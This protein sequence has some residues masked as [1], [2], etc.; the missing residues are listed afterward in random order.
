MNNKPLLITIG[1]VFILI[2]AAIWVYLFLYGAPDEPGEVYAN[3]GFELNSQPITVTTPPNQNLDTEEQS[4]INTNTADNPLRQITTR[5]V[6]GFTHV[7]T[8]SSSHVRY[9]ERGTGYVYDINLTTGAETAVSQITIPRVAEAVFSDNGDQVAMTSYTGYSPTSFAGN[10]TDSGFTYSTLEPDAH[11][12]KFLA[13]GE[14]LYAVSN[15]GT[16]RGYMHDLET[17]SRRELFSFDF[18]NTDVTW[19]SDYDA[20]YLTTRPAH[21]LPGYV[22]TIRNNTVSPVLPPRVNMHALITPN[23]TITTFN[24]DEDIRTTAST[25][26]GSQYTLPIT[27]IPQKCAADPNNSDGLWCTGPTSVESITFLEDWNKGT[28]DT[29]DLIWYIDISEETATLR[30][31]P[32]SLSGRSLDVDNIAVSSVG[33]YVLLRNRLDQTLWLLDTNTL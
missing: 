14:V 30:A 15:N 4:T 20:T 22:Y 26:N 31:N 19:G 2:V 17:E 16:T 29:T 8:A 13:D 10:L 6:A 32:D 5:P 3:L 23:H 24:T 21:N 18:V 25:P 12:L 9:V 27:V 1:I 33:R 11:S 7:I 28:V